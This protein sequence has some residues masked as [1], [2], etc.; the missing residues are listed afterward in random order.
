VIISAKAVVAGCALVFLGAIGRL[1]VLQGREIKR[2][3]IKRDSSELN[4]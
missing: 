3:E 2:G 4:G 1:F